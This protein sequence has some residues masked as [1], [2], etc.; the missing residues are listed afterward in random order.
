MGK[1]SFAVNIAEHVSITDKNRCDIQPRNAERTDCKTVL[2][3]ARHLLIQI[4]SEQVI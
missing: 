2:Y 1:S 3:A 4:K